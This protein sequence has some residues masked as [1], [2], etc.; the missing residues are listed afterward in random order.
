MADFRQELNEARDRFADK[1]EMGN[2]K[3]KLKMNL[4][5]SG[6]REQSR[7]DEGQGD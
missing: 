7:G 3:L 6:I 5:K 1:D 2:K 4:R